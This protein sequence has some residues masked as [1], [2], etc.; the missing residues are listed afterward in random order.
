MMP[1]RT[2][3]VQQAYRGRDG[4]PRCYVK[5]HTLPL[6][7]DEILNEGDAVMIRG[8]RAERPA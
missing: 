8:N 4:K 3:T 7:T 1:P 2:H 5:G 6:F